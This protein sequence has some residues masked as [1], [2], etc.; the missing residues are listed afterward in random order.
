MET[1]N[2]DEV[3]NRISNWCNESG[4]TDDQIDHIMHEINAAGHAILDDLDISK[5]K[6]RD[7]I[8]TSGR[9][10]VNPT[11]DDLEAF[12][13]CRAMAEVNTSAA[14]LSGEINVHPARLSVNF[15]AD[16]GRNY[17]ILEINRIRIL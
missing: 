17:H 13:G 7:G 10:I 14:E 16:E 6:L 3:R 15:D 8:G 12:D 2:F 1:R 5:I 11:V 4:L 9:T